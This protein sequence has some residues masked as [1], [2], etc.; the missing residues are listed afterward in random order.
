M[1]TRPTSFLSSSLEARPINGGR[2]VFAR[3]RISAGTVLAVW[4]GEVIEAERFYGLPAPERQISVQVE[5]QLYLVPSREGAAEWVNHSCDPNAGMLGQITLVALREIVEG[6]EVRYDY[7]MSD[8]SPYDEFVC[9]CGAV[10]C[11]K[12]ITGEDWRRPELW[13]RYEGHFSPYLQR[14][15]ERL[16][17]ALLSREEARHSAD[18]ETGP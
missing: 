12:R 4:G 6:E 8:G 18:V 9:H 1:T 11:R 17:Q 3:R 7:A 10:S 15:I 5:E 14:R 13:E 16:Q 2:G